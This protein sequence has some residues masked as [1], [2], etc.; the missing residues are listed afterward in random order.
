M[1]GYIGENVTI[2]V[3]VGFNAEQE[4]Y[5]E[6]LTGKLRKYDA[7][8][9]AYLSQEKDGETFESFIPISKIVDIRPG[10]RLYR[11]Y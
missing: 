8:E 10:R 3:L 9:G 2:R 5:Y 4:P 1:S 7:N 11:Y 6:H